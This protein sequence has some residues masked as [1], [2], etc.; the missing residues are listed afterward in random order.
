MPL[1]DQISVAHESY[2]GDL[3]FFE[4][5][6]VLKI[7]ADVQFMITSHLSYHDLL[8]FRL[9]SRTIAIEIIPVNRLI[10]C[11]DRI[12]DVELRREGSQG[13]IPIDG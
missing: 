13:A 7:A 9:T 6:P 2:E 3:S 11:R 4:R 1:H 10:Q 8:N 5:A 12:I